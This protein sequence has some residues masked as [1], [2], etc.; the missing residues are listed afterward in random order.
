MLTQF[1]AGAPEYPGRSEKPVSQAIDIWSLGCV[2][3]VAATWIILGHTG[4]T[5]YEA[6][7]QLATRKLVQARQSQNPAPNQAEE[8]TEGDQFH[9]GQEV[10]EAVTDWHQYLRNSRRRTDTITPVVLNLVDGKMLLGPAHRRINASDLC[11][12]LESILKDCPSNSEPQLP[13]KLVP[14]LGEVD[15]EASLKAA[16]V[17]RSR[18]MT[19]ASSKSSK[20]VIDGVQNSYHA[21][22]PLKTTHRQ[23]FWPH[24]SLRL[25]DG[26]YLGNQT[27]RL[28]T[29]PEQLHTH[30][31]TVQTPPKTITHHTTYSNP[32]VYSTPSRPRRRG[33]RKHHP[34]NYFQAREELQKR[35]HNGNINN[36]MKFWKHDS[37]D[38]LLESYFRGMRDIVSLISLRASKPSIV[39]TS[40]RFFW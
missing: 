33:A 29:S 37:K 39:L 18:H 30:D 4:V 25:H 24:Q 20:I 21:E 40:I 10:L 19:K 34:Q 16:N 12:K 35:G 5:Q 28:Q 3:S 2:F 26:K 22:R 7:R 6:V 1:D 13:E 14:L 17:R 23:S 15:E 36:Q 9:D 11:S 38:E 27:L 8:A 31:H 32:I